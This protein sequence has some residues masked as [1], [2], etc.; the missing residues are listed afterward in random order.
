MKDFQTGDI[1]VD[2]KEIQDN[3]LN[4]CASLL[5][6]DE[7]ED[8]YKTEVDLMEHLH[9]MRMQK[10]IAGTEEEEVLTKSDFNEV[11]D[12]LKKG[13]KVSYNFTTT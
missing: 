13:G 1:L 8:D 10:H 3:A 9:S 7:P 6:N 11:I 5:K 4:Y 12:K 2:P